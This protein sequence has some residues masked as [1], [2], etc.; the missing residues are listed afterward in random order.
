[1]EAREH[2]ENLVKY[3]SWVSREND[4]E[5]WQKGLI[6]AQ[7]WLRLIDSNDA[8]PT[9]LT[10]FIDVVHA[11]RFRSSGWY[12]L[13]LGAY[14]WIKAKGISVSPREV[15]FASEGITIEM[16]QTATPLEHAQT[17]ISV[18]EQYKRED[19]SNETWI[20]GSEIVREWLK[21]IESKELRKSEVSTLVSKIFDRYKDS[22][23]KLWFDAAIGISLWCKE[24]GNLDL[25]PDDFHH[26]L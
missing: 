18:F 3:F 12:D 2:A 16:L 6:T 13:A 22:Y 21:L 24:T 26:L 10:T 19:P 9:E 14:H 15:F 4:E 8:S 23:S 7:E 17:L 1:M 5:V 11:N 25:I 20:M